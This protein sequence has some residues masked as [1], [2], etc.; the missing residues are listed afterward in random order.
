MF[1]L[2]GYC[3]FKR[4]FLC[5]YGV[6]KA[7]YLRQLNKGCEMSVT[8]GPYRDY[9]DGVSSL[10][11]DTEHQL[12]GIGI[13]PEEARRYVGK[14]DSDQ[15]ERMSESLNGVHGFANATGR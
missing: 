14:A 13:R 5:K 10:D 7:V 2:G 3:N 4:Y 8:S 12:L 6:S 1:E 11:D 15:N 9:A